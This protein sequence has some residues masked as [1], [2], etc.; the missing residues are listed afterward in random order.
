MGR[1]RPGGAT[2]RKDQPMSR[3]LLFGLLLLGV[4]VF[5]GTRPTSDPQVVHAASQTFNPLPAM[6]TFNV[7]AG[8]TQVRIEVRGA[9]G[10][11]GGA[12]AAG[13]VVPAGGQGGRI[14]ATFTLPAGTTQLFVFVGG[15]GGPPGP[16][17]GGTGGFNGGAVGGS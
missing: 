17:S 13:C 10:G 9:N 15:N 2:N 8:V 5:A 14:S 1:S 7:P 16:T 4:A 6:Q 3:I 11:A 12:G